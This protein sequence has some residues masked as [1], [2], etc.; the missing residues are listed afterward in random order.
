MLGL[1]G[2]E[3]TYEK[4][5]A[6]RDALSETMSGLR[7]G[8]WHGLNV[9]M[10]LKE[11]AARLSD[12][13]SPLAE[14]SRSVNT[15]AAEDQHI[16]GHSTD[17]TAFTTLLEDSRFA[18]M[19][20]I[21]LVGAGGSAAAALAAIGGERRV[22]VAARRRA[23]AEK[24]TARFGGE[25]VAWGAAVAGSLVINS[26]PLGMKGESLPGVTLSASAGL[27]DLPY[28][29]V[30]T[31]AMVEA[32]SLEVP[33]ANGHEFLVLQAIESFR[34]WTGVQIA[35]PDLLAALRNV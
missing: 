9:T 11:E 22:Y 30:P 19:G 2:L 12:R 5:R 21:L 35:Y 26:T 23:A 20:T 18:D 15:L 33:T 17:S 31:P 29:Q 32:A 16:A 3:G 7:A 34:L 25:V 6:D 14:R 27:I 8:E 24:L 1:A 4:I 28:G 13:L 10:P